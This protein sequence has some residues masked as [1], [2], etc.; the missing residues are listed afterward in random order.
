MSTRKSKIRLQRKTDPKKPTKQMRV[1]I[2]RKI[3]RLG[4]T[5][6]IT[7]SVSSLAPTFNSAIAS[8]PMYDMAQGITES[9]R[10]GDKI[11][12]Q[13][14]QL[15]FTAYRGLTDSTLRLVAFRYR[16]NVA[17]VNN[18][19]VLDAIGTAGTSNY[20]NNPLILNKGNKMYEKLYDQSWVLDDGK[21]N[22]INK[23]VNIKVNGRP[24]NYTAPTAGQI[25]KDECYFFFMS[26]ASPTNAP[27]V[28]YVSIARYKDL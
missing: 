11:R 27:G 12:P 8:T 28:N 9:T 16:D 13:S 6:Y 5:K 3:Q 21:Q 10:I 2:D 15:R 19:F 24:V 20:I 1:Y 18:N 4:E 17:A 23:V 26:D 14:F 25:R 22:H 7:N